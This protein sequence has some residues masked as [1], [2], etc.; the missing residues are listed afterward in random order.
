MILASSD[1]L[2]DHLEKPWQS[3][4]WPHGRYDSNEYLGVVFCFSPRKTGLPLLLL[5]YLETDKEGQDPGA[6]CKV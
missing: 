3:E 1:S 2:V 4:V 6:A 5:S